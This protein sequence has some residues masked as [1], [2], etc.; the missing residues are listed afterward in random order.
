MKMQDDELLMQLLADHATEGISAKQSAELRNLLLR[1][2]EIDDLQYEFAAAAFH[3]SQPWGLEPFPQRLQEKVSADA[4]SYFNSQQGSQASAKDSSSAHSSSL[5]E[6]PGVRRKRAF[7]LF[8][9]AWAAAAAFLLFAL[10]GWGLVLKSK[11][12]RRPTA[13]E[14]RSRLLATNARLIK[15][16]WRPGNSPESEG[17]YGDVIW[18]IAGQQGYMHF[19]D[20]PVNDPNVMVY[21]LWIFDAD[22]DERYPVDGGVFNINRKGDVIVPIKASLKVS[23]PTLFAITIEKPGGVMVSKR[24]RLVLLG[25]VG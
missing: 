5:L 2:P 23:R 15:A 18:N 9:T 12:E 8:T 22:Q 24:D 19:H 20:L 10:G 17:V 25:K 16:E 11:L 4:E 6:F 3:L 1:N 21:Q 14:A 13:E 7:P